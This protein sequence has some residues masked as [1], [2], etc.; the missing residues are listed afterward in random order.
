M[1]SIFRLGYNWNRYKI[2]LITQQKILNILSIAFWGKFN[3]SFKPGKIAIY[4]IGNIGDIVCSIPAMI[5]VKETYPDVH[6]TLVTSAGQ[7]GN[8]G[9]KQILQDA[10]FI[11]EIFE[12]SSQDIADLNGKKKVLDELKGRNFDLWINLPLDRAIF[13]R[14]LRDMLFVKLVGVKKAIGFKLGIPGS[15]ELRKILKLPLPNEVERLLNLLKGYGI[16]SSGVRFDL[17][18]TK[19]VKEKCNRIIEKLKIPKNKP[20]VGIAPFTK[21]PAK[22][23]P[24]ERFLEVARYLIKKGTVLLIFGGKSEEI[25]GEKFVGQV[26]ENAF[27]LCGKLSV[28]ESAYMLKMCKFLV[29]NDSGPMHLAA[30]VGT[31]CVAIFSA[32]NYPGQWEPHGEGHIILRK[33][34]DCSPCYLMECPKGNL[35][36]NLITVEEVLEATNKQLE[37]VE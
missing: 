20:W 32:H 35:C 2:K 25:K 37:D 27:N 22:Q 10:W 34:V 30:A 31:K 11:D 14:T 33:D 24:I 29:T 5:A 28:L 19:D 36:V 17:P 9:A 15:P 13:R 12:Y 3:D 21:Q 6:I 26:E 18:F 7:K 4:R 23:W 8:I 1:D 16:R